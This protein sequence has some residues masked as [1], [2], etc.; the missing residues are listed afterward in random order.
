M[1][2]ILMHIFFISFFTL[3]ALFLVPQCGF[4][5]T[6]VSTLERAYGSPTTQQAILDNPLL[7]DIIHHVREKYGVSAVI[8]YGSRARGTA[9]D[10]SDYDI[11]GVLKSVESQ[12]HIE[13]F[14]GNRLDISLFPQKIEDED[15][16]ENLPAPFFWEEAIILYQSHDVGEKF[17]NDAKKN[18]YRT[19]SKPS[20]TKE[21][22]CS[23]LE[24]SLKRAGDNKI[25]EHF[26]R[27][28]FLVLSLKEYFPIHDL[29]YKGPRK[30]LAWLEKNDP[31]TYAVFTKAMDP[32]ASIKN[33]QI[34]FA[35]ITG[36][37]FSR[38][39]QVKK[40]MTPSQDPLLPHI[41]H[42]IRTTYGA[43]TIILYGSRARGEA[44]D[45]SDYDIIAFRGLGTPEESKYD[46]FKGASLDI[47]FYPDEV[48][49]DMYPSMVLG[50]VKGNVILCQKDHFGDQFIQHFK[51]I[52][53][54]GFNLPDSLKQQVVD[55]IKTTF[56]K[57]DNTLAG[58]Y[59]QYRLLSSLLGHYFTLRN[60]YYLGPRESFAW[61]KKND[62]STYY[63]FE[64]ALK[65]GASLNSIKQL[66]NRVIT[67]FEKRLHKEERTIGS[68][69]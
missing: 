5:Q 8:L 45:N 51:K 50:F 46:L 3:F 41:E 43:H 24:M 33:L 13:F 7:L 49:K 31:L 47:H 22:S 15:D 25:R 36:A 11:I 44:K 1:E 48:L 20:K 39:P 40:Q 19:K 4:C 59:Y 26:Y 54:R 68:C 18:F 35:Q 6:S 64:K 69:P 52:Y 65:P 16:G 2:T 55:E 42:H 60:F 34:L 53:D 28:I 21:N 57:I 23:S 30:S 58:Y 27:N 10:K 67:P 61:L 37:K 29:P 66:V 62:L 9:S 63:A 12:K 38:N 56:L 14:K 32:Y 17:I